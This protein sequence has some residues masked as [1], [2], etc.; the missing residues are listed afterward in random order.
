MARGEGSS[1]KAF[2]AREHLGVRARARAPDRVRHRLRAA[3]LAPAGRP[4]AGSSLRTERVR[5]GAEAD[6]AGD[7]EFYT[8]LADRRVVRPDRTRSGRCR[9]RAGIVRETG[10]AG[11]GRRVR[12]ARVRACRPATRVVPASAQRLDGRDLAAERYREIPASSLGQ[13]SYYLQAGS[14]SRAEEAERARAV[15][16]LLGLDAFVVTRTGS[17]G[18]TGHR[19]RIGP[20]VDAKR[21]GEARE[22]LRGGGVSYDLIRVSG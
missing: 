14:F 3:A 12:P 16:L 7:Y 20:F 8:V 19:V 2:R 10:A 18:T 17:D 6:A 11:P 15:V 22:R 1:D 13:E 21:L 9:C 5:R 4:G